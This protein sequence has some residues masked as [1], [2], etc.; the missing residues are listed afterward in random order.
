MNDVVVEF[1]K[2]YDAAAIVGAK[3]LT[4]VEQFLRASWRILPMTRASLMRCGSRIRIRWMSGSRRRASHSCRRSRDRKNA[5]ARGHRD[6]RAAPGRSDQ[7]DAGVS[8]SQGRR[9]G[10]PA[11]DPVRRDRHALRRAREPARR[12][13]R[14]PQCR[15]SSRRHGRPLRCRRQVVRTEELAA[16]CAVAIAGLGHLP[17]TILTRSVIIRMRRRAPTE[18]RTLSPARALEARDSIT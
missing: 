2:G 18:H 14:H 13:P 6:A 9:R 1:N 15:A 5:R 16:Y 3:L 12:D 7:R 8:V 11:D 4:D 17:D 10:R